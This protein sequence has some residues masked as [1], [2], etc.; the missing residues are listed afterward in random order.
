MRTGRGLA[1]YAQSLLT[2]RANTWYMY[3][4]NGNPITEKFIQTKKI[5]YPDNYSDAHITELRK[6]IGA[7]GYDCSSIMD[8][9]T[10]EDKSAN[11]WLAAATESG[12]ISSIPEIVG[13][14]VHFNGHVGIYIGAGKVV[15]ARG[16][17]YGIVETRLKDRPW[18][19]WAKVPGISYEE[20][21]DMI[22][23][24][25]GQGSIASPDKDVAEL[26]NAFIRLDI[27]MKSPSTGKVYTT[28]DGSYG[29]ATAAGVQIFEKKYAMPVT[30]GSAFTELH[31]RVLLSAMAKL[32]ASTGITK[33][34][35][36]AANAK[37]ASAEKKAAALQS[38][39]KALAA[40]NR[41]LGKY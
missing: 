15:E 23:C 19:T 20:E 10:D 4:N 6:H 1:E 14:S 17:W 38:D 40:A 26:Q 12:P 8:L 24:K 3:G 9:Y 35:L 27:E 41:L 25:R 37:A 31:V 18:K 5:Q 33:S 11:G 21:D 30:D 32:P 7:I 13:L 29:P 34:Q 28:A 36:D 39:L 22:F 2:G 16:T